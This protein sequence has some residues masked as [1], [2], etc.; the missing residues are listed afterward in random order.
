MVDDYLPST[1]RSFGC[2]IIRL[3]FCRNLL[4]RAILKPR[5]QT[6]SISTTCNSDTLLPTTCASFSHFLA[7][8]FVFL[9]SS[10][11]TDQ[12]QGSRCRT[13]RHIRFRFL[14]ITIFFRPTMG[15]ESPIY[16]PSIRVPLRDG[17]RPATETREF[18]ENRIHLPQVSPYQPLRPPPLRHQDSE[19]QRPLPNSGP[20][21]NLV[22]HHP[23]YLVPRCPLTIRTE[24]PNG[25]PSPSIDSQNSGSGSDTILSLPTPPVG[26]FPLSHVP[27]PH[28]FTDSGSCA[29]P[30]STIDL[31]SRTSVA[32][33]SL[34]RQSTISSSTIHLSNIPPFPP[35]WC[36]PPSQDPPLPQD[37]PRLRA[38]GLV[39]PLKT[40]HDPEHNEQQI[41]VVP[42]NIFNARWTRISRASSQA[43][44]SSWGY[45][46]PQHNGS[47]KDT[48]VEKGDRPMTYAMSKPH[49]ASMASTLNSSTLPLENVIFKRD[50]TASS[51]IRYLQDTP[52]ADIIS[53]TLSEF[54]QEANIKKPPVFQKHTTQ[55][56]D[57]TVITESLIKEVEALPKPMPTIPTMC[58]KRLSVPKPAQFYEAAEHDI[59]TRSTTSLSL[60]DLMRSATDLASS[61]DHGNIASRIDVSGKSSEAGFGVAGE[62]FSILFW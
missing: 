3:S 44:P 62:L 45:D 32:T 58:E 54:D 57:E 4:E 24:L 9:L 38:A 31:A 37:D 25:N 21:S 18:V 56:H 22:N 26:S 28:P 29:S 30:R 27:P 51:A 50:P 35:P 17:Q 41:F 42:Q 15:P 34:F 1:R 5:L 23:R 2:H 14:G 12:N 52:R 48:N 11:Q 10:R 33:E 43:I 61:L 55:Q 20:L 7:T 53:Q 47:F 19:V 36:P 6:A 13:D 60:I 59:K 8:H 46:F 49:P 39:S 40:S 16:R